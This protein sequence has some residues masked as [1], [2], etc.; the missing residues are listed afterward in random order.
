MGLSFIVKAT[1]I[2]DKNSKGQEGKCRFCCFLP[3][4]CP[5]LSDRSLGTCP[6]ELLIKTRIPTPHTHTHTHTHHITFT[7]HNRLET[8]VQQYPEAGSKN[9]HGRLNECGLNPQQAD[10]YKSV[11]LRFWKQTY[12]Y[13][14]GNLAGWGTNQK[15]GMNIHTLLYINCITNKDLLYSTE[16]ST[17]YSL[18]TYV[19]KESE[20]KNG[21]MCMYNRLSVLYTWNT[22]F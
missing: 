16:N 3:S 18:I 8:R 13:Q 22:A 2:Y 11:N 1:A 10:G 14:R 17:Q 15:L 4:N 20:K 19:G 21:Y 7:S 5:G 9:C 6:S 12:D